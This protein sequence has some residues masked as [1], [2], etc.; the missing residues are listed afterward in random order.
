MSTH[1]LPYYR[2][3]RRQ[4]NKLAGLSRK[5]PV[6]TYTGLAAS[7][8]TIA[9]FIFFAIRP[10]LVTIA[11][12]LRQIEEKEVI[13]AKLDDKIEALN[14][15]QR[16]YQLTAP[17]LYL[18]DE[19]LPTTPEVATLIQQIEYL[20]WQDRLPVA[21][22]QTGSV[23]LKEATG[24][25]VGSVG[26]S[27]QPIE[28]SLTLAEG[29]FEQTDRLLKATGKLRRLLIINPLAYQASQTSEQANLK[30]SLKGTAFYLQPTF[31]KINLADE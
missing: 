2:R 31:N 16:N 10:T 5:E 26:S 28:F 21:S 12:L 30:L 24:K 6:R 27:A 19:A 11:D 7:F 9:F 1:A 25:V 22:F 14:Q 29:S 4:L 8:F 15:A 20:A 3:Y 17:R 13:A 23:S 18:L